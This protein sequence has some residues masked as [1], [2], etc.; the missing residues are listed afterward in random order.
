MAPE[1]DEFDFGQNKSF[2][3]PAKEPPPSPALVYTAWHL[4]RALRCHR[5]D[6]IAGKRDF[7]VTPIFGVFKVTNPPPRL[8]QQ[9][10]FQLRTDT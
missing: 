4:W 8:P 10:V 7:T 5:R 6:V 3:L 9:A 1:I 2:R